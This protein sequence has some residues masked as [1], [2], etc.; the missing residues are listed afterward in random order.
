MEQMSFRERNRQR[1]ERNAFQNLY[2]FAQETGVPDPK[3][4]A[5]RAAR[6]IHLGAASGGS[7]RARAGGSRSGEERK[8]PHR[9]DDR[10]RDQLYERAQEL[11][12]EGRSKMTKDELIEAIR[13][14]Q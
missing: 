2:A 10:T 3:R 7:A 11:D 4:T 8:V 13:A 14:E 12:I 5:E 9:L 6:E 1:R